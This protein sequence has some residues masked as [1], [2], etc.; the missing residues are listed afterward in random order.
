MPFPW[1]KKKSPVTRISRIV[2]DFHSPKRGSSLVV[3]TG[4]PTSLIDLFV[5][6]RSRFAR[7]KK[8]APPEQISDP[9]PPPPSPAVTPPPSPPILPPHAESPRP[10]AAIQEEIK[11]AA[12]GGAGAG[13]VIEFGS[14]NRVAAGV[15][16]RWSLVVVMVLIAC[17]ERLTVGITVSSLALLFLEYAAKRTVSCAWFQKK[18]KKEEEVVCEVAN[19]KR[20]F[21][22][23]RSGCD[24]IES[25][26]TFGP[27]L[28]LVGKG[29]RKGR[30]GNLKTK[31]MMVKKLMLEKFRR[32]KKEKKI[33]S[34]SAVVEEEKLVMSFDIEEE[35]DDCGGNTT[36]ESPSMVIEV[37]EIGGRIGNSS[38]YRILIVIVLVGLLVGRFE[39][40]ILIMLW[41]LVVAIVKSLWKSKS[42]NM[43]VPWL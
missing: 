30:T 33:E 9:R 13:E 6:N 42:R 5:K 11:A 35:E 23:S 4:F 27:D 41:C 43:S 26:E 28:G 7:T 8:R 25:V 3:Q 29:G 18:N 21:S 20:E 12:D 22:E 24:E 38:G 32:S 16:V 1:K 36:K 39:A 10:D 14:G 2:A 37:K 17:V 31:S 40:L 34:A 19:F 15:A